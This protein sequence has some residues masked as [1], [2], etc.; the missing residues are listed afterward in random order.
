MNP[1]Q[2]QLFGAAQVLTDRLAAKKQQG[3]GKQG[4][5]VAL[6]KYQDPEGN[7]FYLEEKKTTVKS[8]FS[9]KSFSARPVKHT[10]AQVGQE[11]K[12]ENKEK[13][14]KQASGPDPWKA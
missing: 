1:R 12:E 4:Q 6:W 3:G 11:I 5:G 2:A 14:E 13:R 10:P 8:P 9:G 7:T